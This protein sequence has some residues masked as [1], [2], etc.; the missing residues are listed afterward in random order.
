M[1]DE[2]KELRLE[3]LRLRSL[4]LRAAQEIKDLDG[5]IM[6]AADSVEGLREWLGMQ[7]GDLCAGISSIN[8]VNR[9]EGRTKGGYVE[10]FPDLLKQRR[11]VEAASPEPT[12]ADR[13][14]GTVLDLLQRLR[15]SPEDVRFERDVLIGWLMEIVEGSVQVEG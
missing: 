1:T 12:V 3:I 13:A 15:S 2:V 6:H 11:E 10:N 8:L 4:C 7:E 5:T 14:A 9:L